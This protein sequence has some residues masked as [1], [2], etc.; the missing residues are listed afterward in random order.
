MSG[1]SGYRC[2]HNRSRLECDDQG[3]GEEHQSQ[4]RVQGGKGRN[5][6]PGETSADLAGG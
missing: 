3:E 6:R 5:S 1:V 2:L 4:D